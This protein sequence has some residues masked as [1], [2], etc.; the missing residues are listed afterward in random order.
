NI[1]ATIQGHLW[2]LE[3]G[4]PST[5]AESRREIAIASQRAA[6]LTRQLLMFSRKQVMQP[7]SL[8]LNALIAD[9]GK[10]LTR[11]LGE[12]VKLR[13]ELSGEPAFARVDPGMIEQVLLNLAVNARDAMPAGGTL[14]FST[15]PNSGSPKNGKGEPVSGNW[16]VLEARDT[17]CGIPEETLP[18]IFEPFFTTKEVGKG[19]GLGLATVHGIVKQHHGMIEVQS[20]VGQGTLFRIHLPAC[21]KEDIP[22]SQNDPR[23]PDYG[24]KETI[25]L[26]EDDEAVRVPIRKFLRHL[27]YT[28][29]E[30]GSG[31]EAL[32]LYDRNR[33]AIDLLLTDMVMPGGVNGKALGEKM[34]ERLPGLRIIYTSGYDMEL[35]TPDMA[36]EE[37]FNFL[38]K[39]VFPKV[40]AQTIREALDRPANASGAKRENDGAGA[41][42]NGRLHRHLG[43]AAV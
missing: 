3:K 11:S 40:M 8:D 30:A 23:I 7:K 31:A 27:G 43:K 4:E 6:T 22:A 5:H 13:F 19:T 36:L 39:P 42:G 16:I 10:M 41:S 14:T 17:G 1:L 32:A 38:Q 33:P 35:I 37:G 21:R 18:R 24:G 15:S 28:V 12:D 20:A 25:F 29:I 9:M 34:L 26:V 2:I